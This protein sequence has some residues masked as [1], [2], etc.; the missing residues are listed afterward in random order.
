MHRAYRF[1][2][3]FLL[4]AFATAAASEASAAGDRTLVRTRS[5]GCFDVSRRRARAP[6]YCVCWFQLSP[7]LV[8]QKVDQ[9]KLEELCREAPHRVVQKA[10]LQAVK[11][12]RIT[13]ARSK[14][15]GR[16]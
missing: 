5:L 16:G 11:Q 12:S 10:Q 14:Q 9:R 1:M 13:N 6:G 15:A 2:M 7:V 4:R 8:K 3:G